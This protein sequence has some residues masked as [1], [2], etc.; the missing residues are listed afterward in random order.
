M[1][2]ASMKRFHYQIKNLGNATGEIRIRGVI[3][4]SN[5]DEECMGMSFE[6]EG[7][8][9]K[10]FESELR[11][12]GDISQLNLY[13]SSEGGYVSDGLAIH[14][15]LKR[16]TAKKTCFVDGYAYSI[17]SLI[18]TSC[19]EVRMPANALLM[20][21][22]AEH[23]VH[24]DY[25]VMERAAEQSKAHNKAIRNAYAAK[26]GRDEK[27]FIGL[28]DAETYLDGH[29]AKA[30]G[31]VDVV[32]DEVALS[33]LVCSPAFRSSA[34]FAKQPA[35]FAALF[36]TAPPPSPS[37]T[38]PTPMKALLALASF[39][40]ITVKGDETEDQLAAAVA[41]HKPA[42][43]NV[44]IDFEDEAVK[45]AFTARITEATKDDKSKITAL[46]T[47]LARISALLKNGAAGAAGGN[48]PVPTP[49]PA[50]KA[51][52]KEMNRAEFDKLNA[53]ERAEF[54]RNKGKLID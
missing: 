48:A 23:G 30:L 52:D 47:E 44:V 32:T 51:K 54:F 9:V 31:L 24:G 50:P 37:R 10:E 42:P 38:S 19:E 34:Q 25:R 27:E 5:K 45:T 12:L 8:T 18:V 3:G 33:N 7:G 26:S 2:S 16:H 11:A 13:I 53:H 15:I 39:V 46:E 21:H 14:S 28:M 43:K 6:G 36:D 22:N 29:A 17:A 4:I 49:T 35:R 40:G 20:I 41:A 1:R